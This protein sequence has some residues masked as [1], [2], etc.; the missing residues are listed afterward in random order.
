MSERALAFSLGIH[1]RKI[2]PII[3][4]HSGKLNSI[5]IITK[6]RMM[7]QYFSGILIFLILEKSNVG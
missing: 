7:K 2:H 4:Y 3:S 1:R 5:N 6:I